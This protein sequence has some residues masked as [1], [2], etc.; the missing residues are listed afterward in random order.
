MLT[1]ESPSG[2]GL[3]RAV[4]SAQPDAF[5][6]AGARDPDSDGTEALNALVR[7]HPGRLE[8]VRCISGDEE[9]NTVL[10]ERIREQ[11]GR[12]DVVIANAG[13]SNWFGRVEDTPIHQ[14]TEHF[15]VNTAGVVVLFQAVYTVL[16][17][18][19]H[20]KF[21]PISTHAA[22]MVLTLATP[23][24]YTS[25]GASKA[26]LNWIA[27]KIHFENEW[28]VCFPLAPGGVDTDMA[29][30][31]MAMDTT[32]ALAA[33]ME[34]NTVPADVAA[35]RLIDLI[36]NATREK[37]GGEFIVVGGERLPW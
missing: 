19:A 27:R 4:L 36:S 23:A 20:P 14:L 33:M 2:L 32:G 7:A 5:V 16:K 37:D 8:I 24:G 21:I 22:S 9:G 26:A 35:L 11:H 15:A 3:V 34:G 13:I 6:Y 17:A 12:V 1:R 18:S 10:A 29:R 30:E 31:G 25:Y 28:L